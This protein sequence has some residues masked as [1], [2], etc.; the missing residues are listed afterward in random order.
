VT[1]KG[2]GVQDVLQ[3]FSFD[4]HSLA[5]CLLLNFQSAQITRLFFMKQ[6]LNREKGKFFN[7]IDE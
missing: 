3:I 5:E 4:S 1:K 7:V 2:G 6:P